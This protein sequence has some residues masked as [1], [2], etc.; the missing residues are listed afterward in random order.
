[1]SKRYEFK[2]SV[3]QEALR[4]SGGICEAVGP[5]YGHEPEQGCD[6][7][8]SYGVEYDHY[9]LPATDL[10]SD[11]VA[12]CCA[13]CPQCHRFKTSNYDIPMQ[14]KGRRIRQ[15]LNPETR[16]KSRKPIPR[17]KNFKWASR[18]FPKRIK[19]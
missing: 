7:P 3:K 2:K 15:N 5:V 11:H 6:R 19:E 9:P 13:V 12:N 16:R 4:R 17:P 14:A 10:G 18:P 8:L 1:M